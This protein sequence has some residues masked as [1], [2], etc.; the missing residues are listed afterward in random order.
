MLSARLS[1]R[2]F[3]VIPFPTCFPLNLPFLRHLCPLFLDLSSAHY[4]RHPLA[5]TPSITQSSFVLREASSSAP[6]RSSQASMPAL[7]CLSCP[8][9][10]CRVTPFLFLQ[11]ERAFCLLP[12][13][14]R[15]HSH[16]DLEMDS[17]FLSFGGLSISSACHVLVLVLLL[18][19]LDL[20]LRACPAPGAARSAGCGPS[21][22]STGSGTLPR[23][24]S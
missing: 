13:S 8:S 18:L 24:P 4:P 3:P 19:R 12:P 17:S 2:L 16:R 23:R 9:Y 20:L 15:D 6:R 14:N 11:S 22:R 10:P 5:R 21:R 1:I 7:P